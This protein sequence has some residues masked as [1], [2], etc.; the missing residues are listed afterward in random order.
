MK[1][2]IKVHQ[3]KDEVYL[4][5]GGGGCNLS[6]N[7]DDSRQACTVLGQG[8]YCIFECGYPA[9]IFCHYTGS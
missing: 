3:S 8:A 1:K 7:W 9:E 4:Y 2:L 5:E 6:C